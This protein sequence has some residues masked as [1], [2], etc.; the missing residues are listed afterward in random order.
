MI[1][2]MPGHKADLILR[3]GRLAASRRMD[4]AHGLASILRDAA[5]TG[6]APQNKVHDIL[7]TSRDQLEIF[8]ACPND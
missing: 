4:A 3:S 2:E 6:A 1:V 7:T 8:T 5:R